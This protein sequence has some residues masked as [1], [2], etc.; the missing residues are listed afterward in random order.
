MWA[1]WHNTTANAHSEINPFLNSAVDPIPLLDRIQNVTFE[2]VMSNIAASLTK[3]ALDNTDR[4]VNGTA[5]SSE[6]FVSVKW[7][8]LILP[9]LMVLFGAIFLSVTIIISKSVDAP[10]WKS[11]VLAFLYHGLSDM[12]DGDLY[13]TVAKMERS[14]EMAHVQLRVSGQDER[15]MLE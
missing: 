6:V 9:A 10:L 15:L 8:W 12:D 11:S 7:P 1:Y 3:L 14:A 13:Q 2:T 4:H 5:Y